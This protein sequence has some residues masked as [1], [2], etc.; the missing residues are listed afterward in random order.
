M[1]LIKC[2]DSDTYNVED[3]C[4]NGIVGDRSLED[5]GK[6]FHDDE[7]SYISVSNKNV[8]DLGASY[9]DFAHW[10][11]KNGA[12]SV[13]SVEANTLVFKHLARNTYVL[14][15]K[16]KF[17]ALNIAVSQKKNVSFVFKKHG[18]GAGSI[19]N[20]TKLKKGHKNRRVIT[21]T[22]LSAGKLA[23]IY[24]P[25]IIKMDI[26][27]EEYNALDSLKDY[28]LEFNPEFAIEFHNGSKMIFDFFKNMSYEVKIIEEKKGKVG[29]IHCK[30]LIKKLNTETVQV[31][32]STNV[33]EKDLA[34]TY[35]DKKLIFAISQ[36]NDTKSTDY[37]IRSILD[38]LKDQKTKLLIFDN[39]ST[40]KIKLLKLFSKY[41]N[42]QRI[43]FVSSQKEISFSETFNTCAN[44]ASY[45]TYDYMYYVNNNAYGFTSGIDSATIKAFQGNNIGIVGHKVSNSESMKTNKQ[46]KLTAGIT[47]PISTEGYAIKLNQF[48]ILGQFNRDLYSYR[49]DVDLV[50][51]MH[52]F[53]STVFLDSSH[54]FFCKRNEAKDNKL[55]S[56]IFYMVRN[57][58]WFDECNGIINY[59]KFIKLLSRKSF[60]KAKEF[61]KSKNSNS[62][63]FIC[64]VGVTCGVVIGTLLKVLAS[65]P[66]K[67]AL[68]YKIT[69]S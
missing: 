5:Y 24:R 51:R 18:T 55:F 4:L 49:E 16:L 20:H 17:L 58:F 31:N 25:D 68:A 37:C 29:L 65:H 14:Q 12:N 66:S 7:Y 52:S 3:I 21:V 35:K 22:G 47:M 27:G 62:V 64:Y 41:R 32:S 40:D 13:V 46:E 45:L 19:E 26:E 50:N 44:F 28:I 39:C 60:L 42:N 36:R 63:Y 43:I 38:S 6:Q 8:L 57:T 54:S 30:P 53:G 67:K 10:C 69:N 33:K 48:N 11:F 59:I 34:E 61:K 15:T 9:G 56:S 1:G 23:D 2:I